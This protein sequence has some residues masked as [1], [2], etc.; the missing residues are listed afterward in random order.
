VFIECNT[1]NVAFI[2]CYFS[3]GARRLQECQKKRGRPSA[4]A[5]PVFT[6]RVLA[7]R[8]RHHRDFYTAIRLAAFSGA[9]IGNRP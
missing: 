1:Q 2:A 6:S 5:A 4:A 9:V 7:R 3:S 8:Y